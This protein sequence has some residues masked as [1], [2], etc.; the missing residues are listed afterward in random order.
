M[1]H[2]FKSAREAKDNKKGFCKYISSRK[3]N[4]NGD[5][6]LSGAGNLVTRDMEKAQIIFSSVFIDKVWPPR[7]LSL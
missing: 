1:K 2:K 6:L 3:T 5:S 4:K 7:S